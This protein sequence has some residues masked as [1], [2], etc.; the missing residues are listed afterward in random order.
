MFCEKK[1]GVIIINSVN[2][3]KTIS[4]G[5][6]QWKLEVMIDILDANGLYQ[7]QIDVSYCFELI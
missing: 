3:T 1:H 2:C 6:T 4:P 7:F 5:D